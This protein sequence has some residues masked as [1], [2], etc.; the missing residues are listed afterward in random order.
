MAD[1]PAG[2]IP[3][4]QYRDFMSRF[5]T[6]LAVITAVTPDGRPRGVTCSSLSS[7]STVPPTLLVCLYERSGTLRAIEDTGWF[8]VNLLNESGRAVSERF[9]S[10]RA[11]RFEAIDWTP[12][13]RR[14]VPGL[15]GVTGGV[16][17]CRLTALQPV[18]D[19]VVVV[20]EVVTADESE[21]QPLLY[22]LRGYA[23]W[24]TELAEPSVSVRH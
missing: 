14:G 7:V 13:G 17:E 2:C 6:G 20:G 4:Q 24:R 11:D 23:A 3:T 16:A 15:G 5:P 19:H 22:G 9:A 21:G 8:G 1:E 12:F 10:N 18:A